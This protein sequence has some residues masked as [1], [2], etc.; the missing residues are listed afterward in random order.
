[1]TPF[2]H[3]STIGKQLCGRAPISDHHAGMRFA[4]DPHFPQ[5]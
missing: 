1:M 2:Q 5:R 4:F 3:C